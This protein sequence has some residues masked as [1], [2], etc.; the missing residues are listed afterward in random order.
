ML[1]CRWPWYSSLLTVAVRMRLSGSMRTITSCTKH[2]KGAKCSLSL[3]RCHQGN[4][5]LANAYTISSF[6]LQPWA[7]DRHG[8]SWSPPTGSLTLKQSGISWDAN[9]SHRI[10]AQLTSVL[11]RCSTR[12]RGEF[13]GDSRWL[14][15]GCGAVTAESYPDSNESWVIWTAGMWVRPRITESS[16][17]PGTVFTKNQPRFCL[18]LCILN[19]SAEVFIFDVLNVMYHKQIPHKHTYKNV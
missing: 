8:N 17:K 3:C 2:K 11:E 15:Q 1:R 16:G 18:F 19:W 5:T 10:E 13:K 9:W 6:I 14:W 7:L 12:S 4:V